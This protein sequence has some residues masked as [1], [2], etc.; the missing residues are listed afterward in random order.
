MRH[1]DILVDILF[2][3]I[4]D[5]QPTWDEVL[6]YVT[7]QGSVQSFMGHTPHMVLFGQEICL[8]IDALSGINV[9]EEFNN[10]SDYVTK[11]AGYLS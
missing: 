7:M 10:P 5:N 1:T 6:P 9:L 11:V 3:L 8:P 4:N 2:S